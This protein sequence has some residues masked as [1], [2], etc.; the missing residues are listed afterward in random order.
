MRWLACGLVFL[1]GAAQAI[2]W[3]VAEVEHARA[4]HV[5]TSGRS[6]YYNGWSKC[7]KCGHPTYD[8]STRENPGIWDVE[9]TTGIDVSDL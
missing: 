2:R 8:A 1:A 5:T 6:S 3:L 7:D 9:L 4:L